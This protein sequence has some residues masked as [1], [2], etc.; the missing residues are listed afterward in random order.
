M[1]DLYWSWEEVNQELGTKY[2]NDTNTEDPVL[3][4]GERKWS[5]ENMEG[6]PIHGRMG[7]TLVERIRYSDKYDL[8]VYT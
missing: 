5:W 8:F 2:T 6:D 1:S 4:V 3:I 7:L